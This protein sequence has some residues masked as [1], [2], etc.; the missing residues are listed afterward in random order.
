MRHTELAD[1][2]ILLHLETLSQ[3][4]NVK[5]RFAHKLF[6]ISLLHLCEEAGIYHEESKQYY[7]M[8]SVNT[9]AQT[10]HVSRTTVMQSLKLLNECNAIRRDNY[11][12]VFSK[13]SDDSYVTNGSCRTYVN[14]SFLNVDMKGE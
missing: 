5:L 4:Y 12:R 13:L 6:Y 1:S 14:T 8:L 2:E 3:Q 7:V 11:K 10:F 9:F